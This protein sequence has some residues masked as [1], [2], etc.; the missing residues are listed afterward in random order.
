MAKVDGSKS[1]LQ[2]V[3]KKDINNNLPE[4]D[5]EWKDVDKDG[6]FEW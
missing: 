1:L 4:E 6:C 5:A 2:P 3:H